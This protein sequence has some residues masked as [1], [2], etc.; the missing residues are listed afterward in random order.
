MKTFFAL[1][2]LV[3]FAAADDLFDVNT[4]SSDAIFLTQT[5]EEIAPAYGFTNVT[6]FGPLDDAT[7]YGNQRDWTAEVFDEDIDEVLT[8]ELF[9]VV[10]RE[11]LISVGAST[12]VV[13][14]YTK[15]KKMHGNRNNFEDGLTKIYEG[16]VA[17]AMARHGGGKDD[18]KDGPEKMCDSGKGKYRRELPCKSGRKNCLLL[19][20]GCTAK[21]CYENLKGKVEPHCNVGLDKQAAAKCDPKV[22]WEGCVPC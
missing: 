21:P 18:K 9:V 17:R 13:Q 4:Y 10:A 7:Y 16:P 5:D 22:T 8:E 3:A 2:A 1:L 15:G 11:M 14:S 12:G 6:D 20:V 19:K